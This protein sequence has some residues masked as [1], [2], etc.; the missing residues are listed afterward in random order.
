MNWARRLIL[1]L[2]DRGEVLLLLLSAFR[3]D[4]EEAEQ[5]PVTI[6]R[7]RAFFD[8]EGLNFVG[9]AEG[10]HCFGLE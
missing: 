8:P 3:H 9:E 1:N 2:Q 7:E 4:G 10:N 6:F 5:S